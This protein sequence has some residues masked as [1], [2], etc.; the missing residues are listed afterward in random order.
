M[1]TTQR[2]LVAR[3]ELHQ[4]FANIGSLTAMAATGLA[5]GSSHRLERQAV[6]RFFADIGTRLSKGQP[7]SGRNAANRVPD[8]RRLKHFFTAISQQME[9][10]E[11]L[12][13]RQA[14]KFNV[15][16]LIAPDENKLSDMLQMLLDPKGE[17]GQGDLCLR[18]LIEKLDAGLNTKQT[19]QASVQRETPTHGIQKYLRRIDV[20]AEAG[21]WVAIEN[22][23]D[24]SEQPEQVKDY[25]AH[26][27]HCT[28]GSGKR[29]VLIYLTPEGRR[30]DSL[31]R[32]ELDEAMSSGHLRCWTYQVEVREWLEMCRRDCQAEKI[33]AF[34][35]DFIAYIE[36]HLKREPE[37]NDE[38]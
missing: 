30:P 29:F 6:E 31:D 32:A 11:R 18:L 28:R 12:D 4:F 8:Q 10:A 13:K 17:H 15:F 16:D 2:Q 9:L 22:K 26:L 36:S 23:V 7:Q 1:S 35:S 25:L 5:R 21:D 27:R 19:K 33:R 20:L 14:S 34:L 24:S 37:T 3:P 38:E